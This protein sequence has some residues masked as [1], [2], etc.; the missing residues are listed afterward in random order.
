MTREEIAKILK[1]LRIDAGLTQSEAAE[2]VGRKQQTLASW[3][4]GQSQPDANTLFVL[5]KIYKT[6]VDRA[7]GFKEDN[8]TSQEF[9]LIRKYRRLD[10]HGKEL[11]NIVVEKESQRCTASQD[12]NLEDA[13]NVSKQVVENKRALSGA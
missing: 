1:Q 9:S 4:T 8:L 3:E 7:F 10:I 11:V 12:P 13:K 5:C 6:S 2:Q